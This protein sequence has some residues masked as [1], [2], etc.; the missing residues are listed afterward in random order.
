MQQFVILPRS[1]QSNLGARDDVIKQLEHHNTASSCKENLNV[2]WGPGI[3]IDLPN[4]QDPIP[5]ML[6]TFEEEEIAWNVLMKLA[7]K[8][9]WLIQDTE[10]GRTLSPD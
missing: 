7:K 3:R 9:Q 1:P 6:L 10:S 5:Q 8:C 2:L 4:E